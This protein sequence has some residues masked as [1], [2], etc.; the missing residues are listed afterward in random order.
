MSLRAE[1][2]ADPARLEEL[3]DA[4][5]ELAVAAALPFCA[6]GWLLPWWHSAAPP[7]ARLFSVAA[8]DGER[9]VAL[10]PL[11]VDGD[12]LLP[13]GTGATTRVE[14]L[15]LRG[16]EDE[17]A[18]VLAPALAEAGAALLRLRGIPESSPW[19]ELLAGAWPGGRSWLHE[20]ERMPAP[21]VEL[22]GVDFEQWL[23]SRSSSFRHQ[24]RRHRRRLEERGGRIEL[25]HDDELPAALEAFVELHHARWAARGGS[26]VLDARVEAAVSGSSEELPPDR[27]RLFVIAGPE[28]TVA[29]N[30]LV[31]AGG[32]V[33]SWLSGHDDRWGE[34]SPQIQLTVA[35]IEHAIASG[36][37]RLDLG[38]GSAEQKER[39]ASTVETLRWVTLVPPG[40]RQV[41]TRMRLLPGRARLALS[42]RLSDE[43][44]RRVKR[45]LRRPS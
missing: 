22:G 8:F 37:R 2:I 3:R 42:Q 29:A 32:E 27:F 10:A 25:V 14:P 28:G 17:A 30:L 40:R 31:A 20:D 1:V 38:P 11:F 21:A 34:V 7:G 26:G 44:K 4:W 39:L 19:P 41:S 18:Q 13:L 23:A 15:A 16:R 24:F 9:L 45:L 5:D 36:D 43:Q 35:T 6:P 12:T 33:S